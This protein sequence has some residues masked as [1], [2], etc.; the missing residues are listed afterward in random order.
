VTVPATEDPPVAVSVKVV[1]LIVAGFIDSLK[2]ALSAWSMDTLVAP[3]TGVVDE[4]AGAVVIVVVVK[5]HT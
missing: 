2:V 1:A 5:V 3:F 4:T